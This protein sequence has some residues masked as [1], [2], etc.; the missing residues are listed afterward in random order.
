MTKLIQLPGREK[1][2]KLNPVKL[3]ENLYEHNKEDG[4]AESSDKTFYLNG[5]Q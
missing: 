3:I 1:Q 2:I 4:R 5:S